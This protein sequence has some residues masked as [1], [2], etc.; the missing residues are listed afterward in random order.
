MGYKDLNLALDLAASVGAPLG[1]GAYSRE[2][3][4]LAKSWGREEQDY[5][6]MLLLLEDIAKV[7]RDESRDKGR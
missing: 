1:L 3:Y 4:A 7:K 6:A 5:T 2:L